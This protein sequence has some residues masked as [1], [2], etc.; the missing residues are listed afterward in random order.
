[1]GTRPTE[2]TR[3][4]R[5]PERGVYEREAID[6]ILDE[7]L[8]CHVGFAVDG[9]SYVLPTIHARVGSDLYVHGA[10]ASRMLGAMAGGVPVCVTAT[11]LDGLVLA[12]CVFSHSMNYR[13]VAILGV[14]TDVVD[15]A[16]KLAALEAIVE[17]VVPGRWRE[18]RHPTEVELRSTRVLRLPLDE[19]AAKV[20][21]GGPRDAA[22]DLRLEVWAGVI[23]L[24]LVP[25]PPIPDARLAPGIA[26]PDYVRRYRV[27]RRRPWA[28]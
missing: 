25:G 12:R 24:S 2:R 8:Y 3:V 22:D 13:S 26:A 19:A 15:D 23:P 18:A 14:A 9:Q 10:A 6:A 4:R 21:T 28:S 20:R 16:E 5:H 7:A 17:H 27:E 11:L 1:M